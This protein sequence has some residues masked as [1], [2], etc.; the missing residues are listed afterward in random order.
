MVVPSNYPVC[1]FGL[2]FDFV[3][4]GLRLDV[5]GRATISGGVPPICH[6][7]SDLKSDAREQVRL[8]PIYDKADLPRAGFVF[9]KG[10]RH[11]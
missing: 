1:G 4:S 7:A 8:G 10:E 6:S 3:R 11:E 5:S 9:S 2:N